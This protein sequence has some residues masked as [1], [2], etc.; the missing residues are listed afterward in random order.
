MINIENGHRTSTA[1][2][3]QYLENIGPVIAHSNWLILVIQGPRRGRSPT[4]SYIAG[5]YF[6]GLQMARKCKINGA[7]LTLTFV[8]IGHMFL[9]CP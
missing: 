4:T 3:L 1:V 7:T 8:C 2:E 6:L 5:I 9:C